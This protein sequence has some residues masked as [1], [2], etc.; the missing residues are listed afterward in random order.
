M[1]PKADSNAVVCMIRERER[2]TTEGGEL[3]KN[4]YGSKKCLLSWSY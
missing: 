1:V 4:T 2:E 3:C